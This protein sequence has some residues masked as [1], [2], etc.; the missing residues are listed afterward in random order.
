MQVLE[1]RMNMKVDLKDIA[2]TEQGT[3]AKTISALHKALDDKL[4]DQPL[5]LFIDGAE[6]KFNPKIERGQK[7]KK[8]PTPPKP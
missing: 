4:K 2:V 3:K 7:P 6:M 1:E 8:P 5:E